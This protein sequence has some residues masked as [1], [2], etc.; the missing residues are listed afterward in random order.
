MVVQ[1]AC[2]G[3]LWRPIEAIVRRLSESCLYEVLADALRAQGQDII[4]FLPTKQAHQKR[5][6]LTEP[7]SLAV[8]ECA[9]A[10]V[11][12]QSRRCV[13]CAHLCARRAGRRI[14]PRVR[15]RCA[16]VA[17][18]HTL[19]PSTSISGKERRFDRPSA[20]R[21]LYAASVTLQVWDTYSTID[22]LGRGAVEA[23]P[24]LTAAVRNPAAFIA[25]K[26]AI[27]AVSIYQAE[28]MWRDHH[29]VRAIVFMAASN[30]LMGWVAVNNHSTLRQLQ[31]Q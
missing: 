21:P 30:A 15:A 31:A 18:C 28:R 3:R 12:A 9:P 26:S 10:A 24:L 27:A 22:G 2:P 6:R 13:T 20:L 14:A 29:R 19:T 7:R 16:G 1:E 5:V 11:C 25:L 23:N 8:G 4:G 17:R